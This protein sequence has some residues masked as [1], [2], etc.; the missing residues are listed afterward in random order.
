MIKKTLQER[1]SGSEKPITH[2]RGLVKGTAY[3][4]LL[5]HPVENR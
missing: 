1:K 5:P 4:R 2:Y 3:D